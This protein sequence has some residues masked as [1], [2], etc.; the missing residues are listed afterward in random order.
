M[1]EAM[2]GTYT[3]TSVE[4]FKEF[5]LE[6][7]VTLPPATM[8][9]A[10]PV[11]MIEVSEADG[12]WTLRA[13]T[14]NWG[15]EKKQEFRIGEPFDWTGPDGLEAEVVINLENGNRFVAIQTPKKE[16][17]GQKVKK[18]VREFNRD[19]LI[20]TMTTVGND[21]GV[22]CVQKFKRN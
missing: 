11:V 15:V 20:Q 19:E 2:K 5:M 7:G 9:M 17:E 6:V 18:V 22:V 16:E 8:P 12:V 10:T 14:S 21:D 1:T 3:R 13:S 4:N